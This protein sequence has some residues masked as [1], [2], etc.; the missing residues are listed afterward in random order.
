MRLHDHCVKV[1]LVVCIAFAVELK[2]IHNK[3]YEVHQRFVQIKV[4]IGS[5][6]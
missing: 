6:A 4:L 3:V 1:E 2:D 5:V